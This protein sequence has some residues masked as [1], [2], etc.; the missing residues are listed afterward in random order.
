MDVWSRDC[1]EK[2][3]KRTELTIGSER[4]LEYRLG[5]VIWGGVDSVEQEV[6]R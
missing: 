6:E 1:E 3:A 2:E 5:F 4:R